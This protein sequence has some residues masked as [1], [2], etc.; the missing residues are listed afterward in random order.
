[1]KDNRRQTAAERLQRCRA[2]KDRTGLAEAEKALQ[3]YPNAFEI[4]YYSA[5]LYRVFGLVEADAAL[6]RRA[7][8]LL[9]RARPLLPQNTD[10][11][12]SETVLYAET[13]QTLL[14]L[15]EADKA[16]Q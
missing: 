9:E 5:A 8:E 16:G 7:L 11:K 6:L 13:A 15:G 12:I 2:E 3:K 14:S 1:M 10:P 4:V